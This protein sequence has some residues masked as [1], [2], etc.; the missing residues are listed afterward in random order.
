[1]VCERL[2]ALQKDLA[3]MKKFTPI[4]LAFS[5]GIPLTPDL[6]SAQASDDSAVRF[7]EAAQTFAAGSI[8]MSTPRDGI[9]NLITGDNQTTGARMILGKSDV[10]YLKLNKPD[11]V[12][13]GDHF[14]V[15]RRIRKVFH[16]KTGD[17]L[18]MITIRVA[19]V[20]AIQV[21]HALTTVSVVRSYG[22][23]APGDPVMRFVPPKPGE[24][25]SRTGDAADVSGMIVEIQADKTMTMVSQADVVYLDRGRDDGLRSG[26]LM[27]VYRL[28]GGLPSRKIGQLKVLST[29]DRTATARIAKATTRLMRGD[30]YKL[31][32]A[33]A[34]I[35]QPVDLP[36]APPS[37]ITPAKAEPAAAPALA[38]ST[39]TA[40]DA[41]GQTRINLGGQTNFLRYDSGEAAIKPEGYALLD[42]LIV[43]LHDSG[44]ER[45]IRVEGHADDMEIGPSLRS[46]YPSN[47]ELSKARA[48]GVVRYLIEKGGIDS[49]RLSSVGYGDSKPLTTNVNEEGRSK[50]RRVEVLLYAPPS[51]AQDS[52][53]PDMHGNAGQLGTPSSLSAKGDGEKSASPADA[54]DAAMPATLLPSTDH[55]QDVAPTGS[56]TGMLNS[57]DGNV[58]GAMTPDATLPDAADPSAAP[59]Q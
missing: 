6:S 51:G 23:I 37:P 42:Q 27:E 24:E 9:V 13:V 12:A 58:P 35:S 1:M 5:L 34:P 15:Y 36:S 8:Q 10:L 38:A 30:R 32:V 3:I 14:T 49:A 43:H 21:D 41:S 20:K 53:K 48:S 2:L 31:T 47:Y 26:D 22:A 39:F 57:P 54:P 11:E 7:G 29:E 59:N 33:A 45:L 18:G 25:A 40:P 16:P 55:G 52:V 19:I 4:V 46:R 28:S 50:N 56:G 44:D 17:Y